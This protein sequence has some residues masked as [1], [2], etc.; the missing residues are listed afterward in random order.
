MQRPEYYFKYHCLTLVEEKEYNED[1]IKE[2]LAYYQTKF[3]DMELINQKNFK[4]DNV[5]LKMYL[6]IKNDYNKK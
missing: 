6:K 3:K 1:K 5:C 2:C 4:V